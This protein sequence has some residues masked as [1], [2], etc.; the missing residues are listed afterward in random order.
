[1]IV[2]LPIHLDQYVPSVDVGLSVVRPH[3]DGLSVEGVGLLQAGLVPGNQVGQVEEHVEMVR[4]DAGLVTLS[5]F[6]LGQQRLSLPPRRTPAAAEGTMMPEE[7]MTMM[8]IVA[9]TVKMKRNRETLLALHAY[10]GFHM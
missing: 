5:R 3:T 8:I 9:R 4:G 7:T 10:K 6:G 2:Y 1:M